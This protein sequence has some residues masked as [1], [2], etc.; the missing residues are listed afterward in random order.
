MI[1]LKDLLDEAHILFA[2]WAI[3]RLGYLGQQMELALGHKKKL[4]KPSSYLLIL[5]T[6]ALCGGHRQSQTCLSHEG[7][8]A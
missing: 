4:L 2:E 6:M 3:P 7:F 1:Y 8:T 5:Q